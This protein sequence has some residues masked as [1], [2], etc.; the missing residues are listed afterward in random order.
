MLDDLVECA[1]AEGQDAMSG[2]IRDRAR[3]AKAKADSEDA[4]IRAKA[5]EAK[6]DAEQVTADFS[7]VAGSVKVSFKGMNAAT[8]DPPRSP[9]SL[10]DT[11]LRG[12]ADMGM[13]RPPRVQMDCIEVQLSEH[14]DM[15]VRAPLGHYSISIAGGSLS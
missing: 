12:L 8:V 2:R 7:Y 11:L 6:R 1:T 5:R 4:E 10:P 15:M 9:Y 14:T 3:V 13:T